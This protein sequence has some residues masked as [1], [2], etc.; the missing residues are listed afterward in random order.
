M[1]LE[2]L[3]RFNGIFNSVYSLDQ[4]LRVL[5]YLCLLGMEGLRKAGM[6]NLEAAK[7][8]ADFYARVSDARF[9]NRFFSLPLMVEGLLRLWKVKTTQAMLTRGMYWSMLL[10]YP[11]EHVWWLSTL[12]PKVIPIDSDKWSRV[13]CQAWAAYVVFDMCGTFLRFREA[14]KKGSAATDP[15]IRAE[16]DKQMYL[17]KVWFSVECADLIMALHWS[18]PQGPLSNIGIGIAGAYGGAAG[19]WFKWV[20]ARRLQVYD[21]KADT[22]GKKEL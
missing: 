1:E 21:N 7:A 9:V 14:E 11:V 20:K 4:G 18:V 10:Y 13:S 12:A 6:D 8:M 22:N 19:L 3:A 17:E 15:S 16:C 2:A 5:A